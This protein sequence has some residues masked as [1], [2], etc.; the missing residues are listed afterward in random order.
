MA[1]ALWGFL[2]PST[3]T[4]GSWQE[5]FE[6]SF[7]ENSFAFLCSC[8]LPPYP[9]QLDLPS[10]AAPQPQLVGM[11]AVSLGEW[12]GHST[13]PALCFIWLQSVFPSFPSFFAS[14]PRAVFPCDVHRGDEWLNVRVLEP[15]LPGSQPSFA[16]ISDVPLGKPLN[17]T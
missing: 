16:P 1:C 3:A 4:T 5:P 17:F 14:Q 2:C 8:G 7:F 15:D 12:Q 11:N 9:R 10:L 6:N 13:D